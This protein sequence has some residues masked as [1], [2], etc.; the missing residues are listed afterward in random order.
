MQLSRADLADFAYFLAI[1]QHGSF[2]RAALAMGVT[3]SALSHAMR[4]LEERRGV[5][6]LNR[7]TRSVTLTAAGEDLRAMIEHPMEAIGQAAGKLD[8]YREAPAGRIRINVLEDAVGLL[9]EPVLPI[10]VDRYPEVQIDLGV[11]NRMI[12]IVGNGFDAGIRYGGTVPEDMIAQRLSPDMRWIAAAAPAYL[13]RFGMPGTPQDLR[14]H[15]CIGIRLGNDQLYQWE[16][17]RDGEAVAI[18]TP[19]PLT[20]DT[21]IAMLACGLSGTGIIYASEPALRPHLRSGAL[22]PVLEDWASSGS[23]FHVYY[24]GRRHVPAG[25][26]LLIDLIREVQPMRLGHR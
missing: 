12:D 10:F 26:Q 15:R 11:T 18:A 5:R 4:A 22:Q 2:K 14:H 9:L 13:H 24:S 1:A 7:T 20:V 17:E 6:L 19:G 21:G 25:L 23:G 8:R 16:F 3:T